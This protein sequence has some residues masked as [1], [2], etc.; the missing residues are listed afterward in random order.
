MRSAVNCSGRL[1]AT[2]GLRDFVPPNQP[3][4]P[5]RTIRTMVNDA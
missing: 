5:I 3:L 1:F 4:R 2:L